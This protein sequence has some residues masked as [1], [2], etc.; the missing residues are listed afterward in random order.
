QRSGGSRDV[1]FEIINIQR[2]DDVGV[3]ARMGVGE[4]QQEA[5]ACL[6]LV[7][8]VVQA[9]YLPPCPA[10]FLTQAGAGFTAG[11]ATSHNDARPR[12]RSRLNQF[13]MLALQRRVGN[14]EG[15]EYS[16][17]DIGRSEEHTSEL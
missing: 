10:V 13:L 12:V 2:A 4:P 11:D 1:F 9:G 8:Q 14:L 15:V 3:H 16:P 7:E 6:A 5:G 17:T